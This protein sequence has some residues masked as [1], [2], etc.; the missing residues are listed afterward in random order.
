MLTNLFQPSRSDPIQ[1]SCDDFQPFPRR[2]DTYSFEH[3]ESFYEE[4][5][6][7]PLCSYFS[8]HSYVGMVLPGQ[9]FNSG[10]LQP[11]FSSSCYITEDTTKNYVFVANLSMGKSGFQPMVCCK[12]FSA[13]Y[14]RSTSLKLGVNF[15]L[16]IQINVPFLIQFLLE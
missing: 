9:E 12:D 15:F 6:Q 3:F 4:D 2:Y 11:S 7:L 16:K 1:H 13:T 10:D 5:F 8:E 14:K